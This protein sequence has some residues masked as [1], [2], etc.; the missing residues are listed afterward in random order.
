MTLSLLTN[1]SYLHFGSTWLGITALAKEEAR[2]VQCSCA[3]RTVYSFHVQYAV[4]SYST[5]FRL[6]YVCRAMMPKH[7]SH[8]P[9]YNV[10]HWTHFCRDL[11]LCATFPPWSPLESQERK[12]LVM[13]IPNVSFSLK[14]QQEEQISKFSCDFINSAPFMFKRW[15]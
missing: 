9:P 1:S 13:A 2:K 3:Q 5:R 8:S 6:L 4:W 7:F 15:W 14:R 12:Q 10:N 11:A